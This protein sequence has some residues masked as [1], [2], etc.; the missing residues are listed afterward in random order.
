MNSDELGWYT[1]VPS[2]DVQ[3][4]G[5]NAAQRGCR[6]HAVAMQD[7]ESSGLEGLAAACG[8]RPR[9]GWDTAPPAT[10]RCAR[11]ERAL[12]LLLSQRDD[13]PEE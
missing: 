1:T 10:E 6:V 12:G 9:R 13:D 3:A 5:L 2:V 7:G 8:L 11:C 4:T